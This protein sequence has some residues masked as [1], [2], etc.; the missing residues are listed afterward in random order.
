MHEQPEPEHREQ[1]RHEGR[2]AE[3]ELV[4]RRRPGARDRAPARQAEARQHA[5]EHV[6]RR[7]VVV[8]ERVDPAGGLELEARG[9]ALRRLLDADEA[10]RTV[11]A[12]SHQTLPWARFQR[13]APATRQAPSSSSQVAAGTRLARSGRGARGSRSVPRPE[14]RRREEQRV[15][16]HVHG[17]RVVGGDQDRVD[18][19]LTLAWNQRRMARQAPWLVGPQQVDDPEGETGEEQQTP[20][21]EARPGRPE[22]RCKACAGRHRASR[23]PRR[24]ILPCSGLRAT[25]KPVRL[26]G[27]RAPANGRCGSRA[28]PAAAAARAATD[29]APPRSRRSRRAARR[30][31]PCSGSGRG[32]APNPPRLGCRTDRARGRRLRASAPRRGAGTSRRPRRCAARRPRSARAPA[33]RCAAPRPPRRSRRRGAGPCRSRSR[34]SGSDGARCRGPRSQPSPRGGSPSPSRSAASTRPSRCRGPGAPRERAAERS[35][36]CGRGRA[37][38]RRASWDGSGR[39]RR[40]RRP[41]R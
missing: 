25:Y 21:A 5:V 2:E 32:A 17:D 18:A 13:S 30:A 3:G 12:S 20:A 9:V 10:L 19:A 36:R 23:P 7:L 15:E 26:P 6:V 33:R 37:R 27:G 40:R 1:R 28:T 22:E 34:A 35:G 4:P 16:Q 8:P 14:S 41:P 11:Q 24:P 38:P 29:R 31:P 39:R